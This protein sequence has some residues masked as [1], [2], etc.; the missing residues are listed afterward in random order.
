MQANSDDIN[1]ALESLKK[2]SFKSLEQAKSHYK[3][4]KKYI[5]NLSLTN[6]RKQEDRNNKILSELTP[7]KQDKTPSS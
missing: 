7:N 2:T 5:S 6:L 1:L 3:S 4:L